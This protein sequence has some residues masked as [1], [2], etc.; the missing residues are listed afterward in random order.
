M[1]ELEFVGPMRQVSGPREAVQ[2]AEELRAGGHFD[3]FR[4]QIRNFRLT[5]SIFRRGIDQLAAEEKLNRLADWI[6][7]TPELFSLNSSS[8]GI[9]A[10]AQHYGIPTPLLD[11]STCPK[12]AGFFA[13][14]G[15]CPPVENDDEV[16][17]CIICINRRQFKASWENLN[18]RARQDSGHDLVRIIEIDVLNLWRLQAQRG[19][20]VQVHVDPTA[21]EM[22]SGFFRILFPYQGPLEDL[23]RESVYPSN[24]SHL[25]TLLEQYLSS[26]SF[27]E[28]ETAMA[29]IYTV[30]HTFE[31]PIGVDPQVFVD[32]CLPEPHRSWSHSSTQLWLSEPDERFPSVLLPETMSLVLP[33]SKIPMQITQNI[34]DQLLGFMSTNPNLRSYS[35]TWRVISAGGEDLTI[36]D[37]DMGLLEDGTYPQILCSTLFAQ[38][39]DG[40]RRF[41]F[42]DDQIVGAL[43]NFLALVVCGY[44]GMTSMFGKVC[45]IDLESGGARTRAFCS[46][47]GLLRCCRPDALSFIKPGHVHAMRHS[48]FGLG[49]ELLAILTEPSR[50]FELSMFVDVF[51]KE[52][53]PSQARIRS[54]GNLMFFNPVRVT[55]L[56][57]S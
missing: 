36:D 24:R 37:Q 54:E 22:F 28:A 55:V 57:N 32:K 4:G 21:L 14:D 13:T 34:A 20:F 9:L 33:E 56:G 45:G 16:F 46:E 39:W 25:E 3:L 1:N 2:L 50:L 26:E 7:R 53:V 27:A 11:F 17:S 43:V 19:L 23:S 51:A 31:G 30:R 48:R 8:D 44:D 29:Q 52:I 38:I 35:I 42:S 6:R 47:Q 49:Y 41:P 12:I 18:V 10:V 15:L 40:M 5:P